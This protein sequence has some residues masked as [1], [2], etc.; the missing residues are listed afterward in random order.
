MEEGTDVLEGIFD[1]LLHLDGEGVAVD[2]K[3]DEEEAL[4]EVSKVCEV[5]SNTCRALQ[6]KDKK[7]GIMING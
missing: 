5:R 2:P 7:I 4:G 3:N 1:G 6:D